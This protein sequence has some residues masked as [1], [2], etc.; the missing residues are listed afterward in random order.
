MLTVNG[1][2]FLMMSD[3]TITSPQMPLTSIVVMEASC[4]VNMEFRFQNIE[5]VSIGDMIMFY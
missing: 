2:D 5:V 4:N 1:L 3:F